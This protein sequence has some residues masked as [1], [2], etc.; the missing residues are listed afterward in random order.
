M[1]PSRRNSSLL[2]TL[3]RSREAR[4]SADTL[5][6]GHSSFLPSQYDLPGLPFDLPGIHISRIETVDFDDSILNGVA[7]QKGT[8]RFILI[9]SDGSSDA[10][11]FSFPSE[12]SLSGASRSS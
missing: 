11:R 9:Q 10:S 1:T 6:S 12:C 5:T 3:F 8:R 2:S 7:G 4:R